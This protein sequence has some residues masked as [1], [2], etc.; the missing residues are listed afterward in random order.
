MLKKVLVGTLLVGFTGVLALGAVNR[1]VDKTGRVAEAQGRG[2]GRGRSSEELV[3]G[4]GNG[5]DLTIADAEAGSGYGQGSRRNGAAERGYSN[6]DSVPEEWV[7]VEGAVVQVPEP[8]LELIVETVDGKQLEIGTGPTD[9]VGAGFAL[10][11]GEAVQVTGFWEDDAFKAV[12]ITRLTTG[13]TFALRDELGR[14]NWAGN[15]RN[16][17]QIGTGRSETQGGVYAPG[18]GEGVG[19]AQ[20]DGWV[21]VNGSV[22]TVDA[23]ALVIVTADGEQIEMI[24]RPWSFAQEQ[25]FSADLSDNVTLTGFYEGDEFE[26]GAIDDAS[27]GQTVLIR[28]TSGR[29]LWAGRGRGGS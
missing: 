5:R 29:P 13:Q 8:G 3:Q 11:V 27:N 24:G 20:V 2:N 12:Q 18:D 26:V 21:K 25:G 14:P 17:Q 16:A 28:D 9:L 15:G 23:D 22:A 19:Q 6:Y 7:M 1:T 10:E 4:Q